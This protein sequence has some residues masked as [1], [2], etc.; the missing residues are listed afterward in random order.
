MKRDTVP[1]LALLAAITA[2]IALGAIRINELQATN[3]EL[4]TKLGDCEA[5]DV[6]F[7]AIAPE[8]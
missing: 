7:I 6:A 5:A 1:W 3:D 8:G 2:I 4:R